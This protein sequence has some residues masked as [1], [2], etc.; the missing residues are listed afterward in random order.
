[1]TARSRGSYVLSNAYH[2]AVA[3]TDDQ[4]SSEPAPTR[5]DGTA[6]VEKRKT[7]LDRLNEEGASVSENPEPKTTAALEGLREELERSRSELELLRTAHDAQARHL[8]TER[9]AFADRI[10][11]LEDERERLR[12]EVQWRRGV[13]DEYELQ[14]NRIHSSRTFRYTTPLRRLVATFRRSPR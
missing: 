6:A 1:M 8:V 2:P 7:S 10:E 3:T 14:L 11:E 12:D 5:A 13:M 4:P 9:L